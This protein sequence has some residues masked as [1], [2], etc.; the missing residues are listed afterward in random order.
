MSDFIKK[1]IRGM[2]LLDDIDDFVDAWHA[3]KPA[4][5]LHQY[6][7]M[8]KSEY[9]L[10]VSDPDVLPYIVQAHRLQRDVHE[11][12]EELQPTQL[13]ARADSPHTALELA[14]WLKKEKLWD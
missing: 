9:S 6:L 5:P 10:W 14:R 4:M 1:C 11:L 2:A 12:L 7:G 3:E 13:A 8:K